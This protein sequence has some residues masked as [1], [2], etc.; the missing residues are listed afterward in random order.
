MLPMFLSRKIT[1]ALGALCQKTETE[2]NIYSSCHFTATEIENTKTSIS[3]LPDPQ[4]HYQPLKA[5]ILS[6]VVVQLRRV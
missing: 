6:Y 3:E 2:I 5:S 4:P 1:R